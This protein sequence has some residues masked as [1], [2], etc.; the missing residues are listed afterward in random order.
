MLK[1]EEVESTGGDGWSG[2]V[3]QCNITE[4]CR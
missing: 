2:F 4:R 1:T 3:G